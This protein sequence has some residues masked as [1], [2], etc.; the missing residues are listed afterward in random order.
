ME[1]TRFTFREATPGQLQEIYKLLR[2]PNF[3][4]DHLDFLIRWADG[5]TNINNGCSNVLSW[6]RFVAGVTR[7]PEWEW[8]VE[9][10]VI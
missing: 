1:S 8:E 2:S 4:S 5:E 6:M 9:W 10:E 3:T 7:Q